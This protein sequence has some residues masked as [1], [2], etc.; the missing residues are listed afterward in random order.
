MVDVGSHAFSTEE[1]SRFGIDDLLGVR[2]VVSAVAGALV[3][4]WAEVEGGG[5]GA[6]F[7][8]GEFFLEEVDSEAD[9]VDGV[10]V[11]SAMVIWNG[12]IS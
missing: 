10:I 4:A 3:V 11:A 6:E 12:M 8:L 5:A 9:D 2:F 1:E 7:G